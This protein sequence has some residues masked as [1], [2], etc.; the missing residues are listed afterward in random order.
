MIW[1]SYKK[2]LARKQPLKL[3]RKKILARRATIKL[4]RKKTIITKIN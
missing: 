3:N 4:N 2:L 1:E